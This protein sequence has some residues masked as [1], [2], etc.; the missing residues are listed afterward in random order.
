M[1]MEIALITL[2]VMILLGLP[3]FMSLVI[4]ATAA[5]TFGD[6]G[7]PLSL[8]HNSLFEGIN[9]FTLLAI[10]C[11]VVAGALMEYGN[12]TQQIIKFFRHCSNLHTK[13]LSD[14]G[15]GP[16]P[17]VRSFPGFPLQ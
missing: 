12:I 9:I 8:I 2:A 3:I 11:F 7:L 4:A 5:L 16:F 15:T 1:T 14:I 6:I 13:S 10:P 17:P